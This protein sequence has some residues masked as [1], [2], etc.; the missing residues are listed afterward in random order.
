MK[1]IFS[2]FGALLAG[3]MMFSCAD[4]YEESATPLGT[5]ISVTPD[6]LEAEVEG[7]G[8][9]EEFNVV[10]DGQ[11]IAVASDW[12]TVEP[13]VG[14]GDATVT[15]TF[16]ANMDPLAPEELAAPRSGKITFMAN[17]ENYVEIEIKQEG[18][19]LKLIQEL[20]FEES[21]AESQGL[22][23]IEDESLAEGLTY[24]WA[25]D[26]AY[27]MKASAFAGAAKAAV[28]Y[29]VS[30]ILNLSIDAELTF[31][32]A[33][34]YFGN[35]EQQISLWIREVGGEWSQLTIPTYCDSWTFVSSGKIKLTEYKG[36]K[37]QI[38]W[39]YESSSDSA[40]TWEIKNVKVAEATAD[41]G[42]EEPEQPEDPEDPEQPEDPEVT[43]VAA[44]IAEVLA[45]EQDQPIGDKYIE[46]IVISNRAL[47][48]LTSKKGMYIQD[49][50][51]GLQLRLTSDHEINFGDKVKINLSGVNMG[52][53]NGAVQVSV[54]NSKVEVISSDNAVEAKTVTMADFLANKY[55]GQYVALEGVQVVADDLAKTWGDETQK[56]HVSINMEDAEG[57]N[58]VVFSSKYSTYAAETVA[59]G[60]GTIKGISSISKGEVQIIFTQTTD[61]AGLTGERFGSAGGEE[62]EQPVELAG[63]GEGTLES[64]YDVVRAKA[65][66]DAYTTVS[67]VY[68]K[69]VVTTSEIK[70]NSTYSSCDYYI[71]VDGT[72]ENEL[73]VYSGKFVDGA[74]FTSADQIHA[75]DEVV[76]CGDLKKHY[77]TY[78][79]NYNSKIVSLTCNHETTEPEQPE[80]PV[81]YTMTLGVT[82]D[83]EGVYAPNA[84]I[85]GLAKSFKEHSWTATDDSGKDTIT[86]NG[87]VY[88]RESDETVW[89]FNKKNAGTTVSAEGFGKVKKVTITLVS[90][91]LAE[92][93]TCTDKEGNAVQSVETGKTET[94]T[95]EFANATD[96]FTITGVNTNAD[97]EDQNY[98]Q[99]MKVSKV[100]IEY[101]K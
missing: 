41:E 10:C 51:A 92:L 94:I 22:F 70:F 23:T 33:G 59:Q 7:T 53:Y 58:F 29:L 42:G 68:V 15:V 39:R 93:L 12:M 26:S 14:S 83:A 25:F 82:A 74:D 54:D 98:Y 88:Y 46:G 4:Q 56:S 1:K 73:M 24:V 40:C 72:T 101:E 19:P 17:K 97:A 2:I 48:N 64:P 69:G 43:L 57:N 38:G 18:D 61:Y 30:P 20:P 16:A 11:W 28:S 31:D 66:I 65:A 75:G 86:F 87:T 27:G 13:S 45:I 50:T 85:E 52:A 32:H 37:V 81:A 100:V 80:G 55:E 5:T 6:A 62:P 76:V 89:Y 63:T 21:F 96:G 99:D 35:K 9:T 95:W 71:S 44:T 8:A 91:K 67:G 34:N 36:K 79:F 49:E 47:N 78:E 60:S 77:E 3:A 84:N 90:K